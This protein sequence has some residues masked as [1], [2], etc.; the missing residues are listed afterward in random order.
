MAICNCI[1]LPSIAP[2]TVDLIVTVGLWWGGIV[3]AGGIIHAIISCRAFV[4]AGP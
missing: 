1:C 3:L 2:Q 4:K